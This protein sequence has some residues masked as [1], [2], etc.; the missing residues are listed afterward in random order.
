MAVGVYMALVPMFAGYVLFGWGLAR[1]R[2]SA[3]TTI[4]LAETVVAA[5]LAVLVVGERLPALAWA[6]AALV[7]GSLFVLTAAPAKRHGRAE[8]ADGPSTGSAADRLNL[9][10]KSPGT[11]ALNPAV[12]TVES[13]DEIRGILMNGADPGES[14]R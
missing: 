3:A 8:P 9:G 7:T 1:V 12:N 13:G 10:G 14:L 2:A 5:I 11:L 6:G 4:S